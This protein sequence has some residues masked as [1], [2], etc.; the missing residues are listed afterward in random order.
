MYHGGKHAENTN[1]ET[2]A[3]ELFPSAKF[4]KIRGY[5]Q[6]NTWEE[7]YSTHQQ[8]VSALKEKTIKV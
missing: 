3:A 7:A 2:S 4:N 1:F 6:V 8:M 5:V